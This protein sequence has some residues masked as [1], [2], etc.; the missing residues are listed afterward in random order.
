M[1]RKLLLTLCLAVALPAAS[2]REAHGFDWLGRIELEA[3]GLDSDNPQ[4]RLKAVRN[5][6]RYAIEWTRKHLLRALKDPDVNV[7]SAAGRVL[8]KHNVVEAVPTI[9]RWLAESDVQSKQV[10][11]DI[12]GEIGAKEGL[13][14]LIRSLGDPEPSVRVHTVMALGKIGGDTIIV[15]LVTRLEDVKPSVRL[16][17][18]GELRELGDARAV[19]PLVGLFDDSSLDVRVAAIGAVGF[20]DD[21][22]AV[23]AL[24]REF[25][26]SIEAVRIAAVTALGNLKAKQALPDLLVELDRSGSALR[27]KIAFSL[28]QIA[29]AHPSEPDSQRALTKLVELLGNPNL[30]NAAK[31]ALLAA[32]PAAV[33][34]LIDHLGGKIAGHPATAVKL[35]VLLA[36][37]R[38]TP[39]LISELDRGRISQNTIL[40]ALS[41]LGDSRALLPVLALLDNQDSGIRLEAMRT[42]GP[43]LSNNS[44]ASDI[45]ADH[46]DDEN[47]AIQILAARYLGQTRSRSALPKLT[48]LAENAKRPALRATALVALGKIGHRRSLDVALRILQNGPQSLRP[49]AADVISEVADESTASRLLPLATNN[50]LLHQSLAIEA[51][52][53]ALRGSESQRAAAALQTIASG[54]RLKPALAATEALAGMKG[55][56]AKDALLKLGASAGPRRKVAAIVGIGSQRDKRALP[57]LRK[58]LQAANRDLSAAAAW[59]IAEIGDTKSLPHLI[60]ASKSTSVATAVN[61]SAAISLLSTPR[62]VAAL[63]SLL[64]H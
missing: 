1:H 64:L 13:P 32:G 2:Q 9:T 35:L 50:K 40:S 3:E 14:A 12:L 5:L 47:P 8:A 59:S 6:G 27:G 28:A 29:T 41:D 18:V 53:A 7:R 49:I 31:E 17:A 26:K 51:L 57:L 44:E 38:A 42:L 30:Q 10:A 58:S 25:R 23:P 16:A 39:A 4:H 48:E 63:S 21:K 60:R 37:K 15:P 43:M 34:K 55:E 24:L 56:L 46:L 54:R 19:V 52:G 62:E 22:T 61:A 20:L 45:I 11:A 33:P 36:D